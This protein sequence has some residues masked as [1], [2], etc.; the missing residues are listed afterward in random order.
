M[1]PLLASAWASLGL[2]LLCLGG[3]AAAMP[4][5]GRWR[6]AGGVAIA[7]GFVGAVIWL[8]VFAVGAAVTIG[9]GSAYVPMPEIATIAAGLAAAATGAGI[10]VASL[11]ARS[12]A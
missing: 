4:A 8:A 12:A 9:T 11:R 7:V 10:A 1:T 6:R 3:A 5:A 2:A